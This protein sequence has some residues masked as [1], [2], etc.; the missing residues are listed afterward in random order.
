[1]V[2]TGL[3]VEGGEGAAERADLV[4]EARALRR[5]LRPLPLP[6]RVRAHASG[7]VCE[8]ACGCVRVCPW[9]RLHVSARASV[10]A[11]YSNG[12]RGTSGSAGLPRRVELDEHAARR[13]RRGG[14]IATLSLRV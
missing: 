12:R 1:M 3:T 14:A 13:R 5:T 8:R 4:L 7:C 9:V 6:L 11:Y 10:Q 2:L